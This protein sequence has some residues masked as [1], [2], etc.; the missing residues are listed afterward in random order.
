MEAKVRTLRSLS[1][2][3]LFTKADLRPSGDNIPIFKM[4]RSLS[5]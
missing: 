2:N 3:R 1:R 5:P 4:F